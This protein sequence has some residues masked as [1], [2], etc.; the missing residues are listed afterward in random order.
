VSA[1]LHFTQGPVFSVVEVTAPALVENAEPVLLAI[2]ERTR[3]EGTRRLLINLMDVVG[4]FGPEQQR[5]IGL[6]A[7]HH[8]GHLERV[9][10]LVPPE[11]L[12]RLSEAAA[13]AQGMELRVFCE[14]SEAIGWLVA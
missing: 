6:L 4:T 13:R 7:Y 14:L 5:A 2:G 9:A 3:Q 10:S 1:S 12:T 8:L 11:K